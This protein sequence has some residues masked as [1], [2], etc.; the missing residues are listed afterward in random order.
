MVSINI[1][2]ADLHVHIV[3][4]WN[5]GF[6]LR[7]GLAT[8]RCLETIHHQL[9]NITL[10][11]IIFHGENDQLCLPAGSQMLYNAAKQVELSS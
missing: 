10:P 11:F 9:K 4:R 6:K 1:G 7:M 2:L 8:L 5:G 3:S